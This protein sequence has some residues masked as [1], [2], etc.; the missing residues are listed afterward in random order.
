MKPLRDAEGDE[1]IRRC[2]R[3]QAQDVGRVEGPKTR[4]RRVVHLIDRDRVGLWPVE[5]FAG[6]EMAVQIAENLE[7]R[8]APQAC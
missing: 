3:V 4:Q 8:A 5:R 2:D 1:L 6:R 7:Y